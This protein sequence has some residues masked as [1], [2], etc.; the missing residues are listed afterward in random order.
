MGGTTTFN[1][2]SIGA[3]YLIDEPGW[4]TE[5]VIRSANNF[6]NLVLTQE[7][8]AVIS[9]NNITL[10]VTYGDAYSVL[11]LSRIGVWDLYATKDGA[12]SL[13]ASANMTIDMTV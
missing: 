4:T 2:N 8:S 12:T 5:L 9:G 10:N 3:D 7:N 1:L 13:V 6:A 11:K